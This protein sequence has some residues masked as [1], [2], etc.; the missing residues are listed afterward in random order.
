MP[1]RHKGDIVIPQHPGNPATV[2][3]TD[4]VFRA[5]TGPESV[6]STRELSRRPTR[7]PDH[8]SENRALVGLIEAMSAASPDHLLQVLVD[9][10][11]DLCRAH[12]A[13]LSLLDREKK[14][15]GWQAIAGQ[16]ASHMGGGTPRDFGPCGT[17]LDR[18]AAQLLSHPERDFPYFASVTPPIEDG[19][20][21]PFEL[22]G[23]AVG[24]IWIIAH[25]QSRRF[26]AEDLR[27][28]TNLAQFA[29]VAYH[30]LVSINALAK[31]NQE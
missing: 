14:R 6:T 3:V 25:D 19:L 21:I 8:A 9:T 15:F 4:V 20:L 27:V 11:L 7:A 13:G 26:D 23:K 24:T 28:L 16:W 12:S 1:N 31:D 5:R 10:A 22:N 17:V 30:A 29:A 2:P 18:G